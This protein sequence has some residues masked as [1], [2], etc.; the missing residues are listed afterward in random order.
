M[1]D[2][3]L[4]KIINSSTNSIDLCT[5][6]NII[7]DHNNNDCKIKNLIKCINQYTLNNQNVNNISFL[8]TTLGDIKLINHNLEKE[9]I[10]EGYNIYT[11]PIIR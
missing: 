11:I 5:K 2:E 7:V 1:R 3:S 6:L 10:K 4:L 8:R 9:L